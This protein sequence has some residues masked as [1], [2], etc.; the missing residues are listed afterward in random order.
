MVTATKS[1]VA[2][3]LTTEREEFDWRVDVCAKATVNRVH[4]QP[5]FEDPKIVS[6]ICD[7]SVELFKKVCKHSGLTN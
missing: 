7:N 5:E 1:E 6:T 4:P 3:F 2:G